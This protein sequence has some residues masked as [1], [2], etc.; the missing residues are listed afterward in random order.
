M[1]VVFHDDVEIIEG[2]AFLG[3]ISLR[4]IIKLLGVREIGKEAFQNCFA[5]SD[6]EFGDELET[7]G[8]DAFWCCKSLRSIKMPSVRTIQQGA[9]FNCY[10]LNDVEFGGDLET[11]GVNSFYDC[12]QLRSIAI[13][14]KENIFTF[15]THE[16]QYDQFDYCE[17]LTTVDL[18]GAEGIHNTISSLL[19]ESWRDEMNQE[20][21]RINQELSNAQADEK[22]DAIRLWI[23]S[24]IN[25]LDCY[26]AEH[27][28][29]LKEHMTQLELAIWKAKLGMKEDNSMEKVQTKR[30]KV[31]V[32]RARKEKRITSGADIIIR[33]V[34]PFLKLG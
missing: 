21:N 5:L 30:A 9:F 33:N 10:Q 25:G 1:S 13:P 3:C 20:I 26:K 24:V 6:V 32:G 23:R 15:D 11:I 31:D 28:R 7:V 27:N 19:M 22:T 4:G 29:L 12:P 34:L 16:Q 14:L 17:N 18:T 8:E 2:L